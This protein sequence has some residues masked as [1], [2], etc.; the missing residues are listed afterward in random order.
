MTPVADNVVS[1]I[2]HIDIGSRFPFTTTIVASPA[3]AAETTIA[4]MTITTNASLRTGIAVFGWAAFTVGT[5]GTAVILRVRNGSLTG[6]VV[7]S[8]G[9]LTAVAANLDEAGVQGF[10]TAAVLP[11]Q[12]YVL[13]MQVTNGAAISTVSAVQLFAIAI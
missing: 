13:T 12:T 2:G 6:T 11:N 4:T 5:S 8:S 9:A 7:V 1:S 3:L 10:D